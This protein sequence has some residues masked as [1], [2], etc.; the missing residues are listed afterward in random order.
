MLNKKWFNSKEIA[1]LPGVP[2]T[3]Q[4]VKLKAR[5]ENW[6]KQ[7]RSGL[8]GGNEYNINSLPKVTQKA[9]IIYQKQRTLGLSANHYYELS[10]YFYRIAK[11]I[12]QNLI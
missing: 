8:G 11:N 9:L 10:K 4:N 6:E 7:K 1:G 3:Q 12:E 5:R 2:G